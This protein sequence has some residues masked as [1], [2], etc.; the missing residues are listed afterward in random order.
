MTD[1]NYGASA[2]KPMLPPLPVPPSKPSWVVSNESLNAFDIQEPARPS[3]YHSA[4]DLNP[5]NLSITAGDMSKMYING[6]KLN[7]RQEVHF[8]GVASIDETGRLCINQESGTNGSNVNTTWFFSKQLTDSLVSALC[9][10]LI[11]NQL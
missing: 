11:N 4:S 2:L 5:L 3:A 9:M 8:D 6:P 1:R 10:V 7:L